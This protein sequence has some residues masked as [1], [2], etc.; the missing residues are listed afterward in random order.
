MHH[1]YEHNGLLRNEPTAKIDGVIEMGSAEDSTTHLNGGPHLGSHEPHR[2]D[3]G[4]PFTANEL[5]EALGQSIPPSSPPHA[6]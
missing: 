2:S 5:Q 1:T 4:R 6:L 3:F